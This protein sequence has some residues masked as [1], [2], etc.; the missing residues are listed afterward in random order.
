MLKSNK[1]YGHLYISLMMGTGVVDGKGS[2][3]EESASP[4]QYQQ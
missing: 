4:Q 2:G 1:I 3:K